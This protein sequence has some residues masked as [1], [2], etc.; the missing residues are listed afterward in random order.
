MNVVSLQNVEKSYGTRLL[1]KDVNLTLTDSERVG[2]IGVNGTGKST[3]LQM[4]AGLGEPD[5]GTIERNGKALVYYLPQN[6]EFEEDASLLENIFLAGHPVPELVRA[7]EKA[8]REDE[9]GPKYL[10]L[11]ERMDAEG[12]WELEQQGRTILSKL[13][14]T[15]VTKPVKHLSGGQRRRLALGQALLYPCWMNRRTI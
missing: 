7:Y 8:A 11:L 10:R 6:P 2:L 3:F 4:V 1:F 5:K 12:G 14:F 13:G 9:G 15:D